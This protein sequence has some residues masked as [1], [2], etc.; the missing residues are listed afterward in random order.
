[1]QQFMIKKLLSCVREYKKD[2]ILSPVFVTLQVMLE[3]TIPM[4]MANLIDKGIEAKDMVYILKTGGILMGLALF[5]LIFG[6]FAGNFAAKAAAGFAKNL[7][8]DLYYSIQKF[9]FAG[10]DKFSTASLVTRLTTDVTNVQ[11]AFMIFIR[12]AVRSPSTLIFALIMAFRINNRLSLIFLCV[13]PILA[14]GLFFLVKNAFPVFEKVFKTYDKLNSIVQENLKGIRVVKSYVREEFEIDKFKDVSNNLYVNYSKAEKYLAFAMP[15]MQ[16][17]TY[18]CMLLISWIGAKLIVSGNMTTG[19]LMSMIAYTMQILMS[20]MMLSMVLVM[21]TISKAAA[22]RISE[23]LDEKPDLT[24]SKNPL[25]VI[26]NGSICFQNVDFSYTKDSKKLCL[27]NVNAII[28]TGETI[29]IIGGTGSGKSSLVQ[30]IPRLYDVTGGTIFVGGKNVKDIDIKTLRDT[31][32]IVLQKNVLFAGTIKENLRWGKKDATEDEI[33]RACELA[34]ADQFI[35]KF[36]AGYD[37]HIEQGG[38][39]ISGGQRQRLCIARALLKQPKI[40]I[41]DDSTSAVD[42]HTDALI[43]KSFRE[44]LP[45]TTKIIIAQRIASVQNADK[46][47]ILDNGKIDGFGTHEELLA[48]NKIYQEVYESQ[49]KG[50]DFDATAQ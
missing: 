9:S 13:L 12:M 35:R 19:Q 49:T 27:Q 26:L 31:V 37:T 14:V 4:V 3:V 42:T 48:Q 17:A 47:F 36:E 7:R 50:G 22:I 11:Q 44:K 21:A 2:S 46:I 33:V 1:M 20:L 29:G 23:V 45:D 40:L 5:A 30:L 25:K 34:Q 15:L 39:N 28:N 32:T 41:L 16:S 38:T 6:V 43:R 8:H 18:I 10:I 24:N